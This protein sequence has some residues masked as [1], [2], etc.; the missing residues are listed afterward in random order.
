M[1]ISHFSSGA[2]VGRL[3]PNPAVAFAAG[4]V[5]HFVIDKIPHY[6]PASTKA[7]WIFTIIDYAVAIVMIGVLL[8]G[9]K[10]DRTNMLWGF[11]GSAS[12]DILLVGVPF[13]HKTRFGQWHTNR[14]PHR[15]EIAF[16]AT[17]LLMA[18]VCFTLVRVI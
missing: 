14:Q 9:S 5:S 2:L 6:W 3:S 10:A 4:V 13:L 18:A 8:V 17:D 15:T 11:A 7:K 12:V 16:L 1:Q